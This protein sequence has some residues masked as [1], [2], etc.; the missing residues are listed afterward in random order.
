M[1]RDDQS[2]RGATTVEYALLLAVVLVGLM[3]A[4]TAILRPFP[5][6]VENSVR[7][8]RNLVS[9]G[10][11]G[12]A[13]DHAASGQAAR[14][15]PY[16][17]LLAAF[18]LGAA[19][20]H[21]AARRAMSRERAHRGVKPSGP[22]EDPLQMPDADRKSPWDEEQMQRDL[23]VRD[24]LRTWSNQQFNETRAD[25]IAVAGTL[26][27]PELLASGSFD[28][29]PSDDQVQAWVE[30]RGGKA[31]YILDRPPLVF[32]AAGTDGSQP[33][34]GLGQRRPVLTLGFSQAEAT[35]PVSI[36]GLLDT[37]AVNTHLDYLTVREHL[38][39]IVPRR[40]AWDERQVGTLVL[41]TL[42]CRLTVDIDYGVDG[43]VS[44]TL[45][46][47][48]L[49][50]GLAQRLF[51]SEGEENLRALFGTDLLTDPGVAVLLD[52]H[53]RTTTVVRVHDGA[54]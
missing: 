3:G 45:Y 25:W 28:E 27:E 7:S 4:W 14:M 47:A 20:A 26:Q 38:R 29:W 41:R 21:W 11:H 19:V 33:W 42:P 12:P 37:G 2:L 18:V 17:C 1:K 48:Y 43:A 5:G 8:A 30:K 49:C 46:L 36:C 13:D 35:G 51:E 16:V 9:P 24:A 54:G 40:V 10:E 15:L 34:R 53:N 39:P 32:F 31:V 22:G 23:R 6:P 52:G 44:K 50:Q